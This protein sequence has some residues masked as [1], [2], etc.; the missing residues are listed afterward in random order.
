MLINSLKLINLLSFSSNSDVTELKPLNV[1]IGPNGSGKSNFLE[2]F[3]LLKNLP[4]QLQKTFHETGGVDDWL[5]RGGAYA[6]KGNYDH[7][8]AD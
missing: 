4:G 8:I 7:A 2:A 6:S 5:W 3:G 1:I